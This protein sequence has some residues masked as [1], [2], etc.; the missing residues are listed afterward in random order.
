MHKPSNKMPK[1]EANSNEIAICSDFYLGHQKVLTRKYLP[2]WKNETPLDYEL[3]AKNTLFSNFYAP[4]IDGIAGLATTKEPK[5]E[6]AEAIDLDNVDLKGNSFPVYVKDVLK[7]SLIDGVSFVSA[8]SL[9]NDV[10]F[11]TH[12]YKDLMSYQFDGTK[13]VQIVFRE[14][15]E[16]KDDSYGTKEQIRF[17]VFKI[18]GGDI[19]CGDNEADI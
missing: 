9:D 17:T 14:T 8:E 5:L 4:I 2:F 13:L 10:Y 11:K 6:K 3:R 16:V 7:H 15:I 1:L 18:G 12:R 19:R